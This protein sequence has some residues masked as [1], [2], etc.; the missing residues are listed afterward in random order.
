MGNMDMFTM[1]LAGGERKHVRLAGLKFRQPSGRV[2]LRILDE[3]GVPSPARV[4]VRAADGKA[5]CPSGSPIYY[6]PLGPDA[7]TRDGF[8]LS[9][10]DDTFPAPA[11]KLQLTALKGVE[12]ALSEQSV[13]VPRGDIAEVT[14]TMRRWT[15]WMQRGWYSGENHYHANYNGTYY[16]RP[17]ESMRWLQAEDLNAANM[18][19]ANSEGAFIHDKEFFR[20]APDPLSTGRYILYWGQEYRNSSP[21]GHMAFLNI[22]KQVPPSYTSVIGSDSPYDFPLNTM[23]A[24]EARKQGGLVSYVHPINQGMRDVFDATLGAKE[25]AIGTALGAVDSIDILPFGE[26]AYQLWYRFL[27]CG[28]HI[29]AGAG[30]DAFANWRSINRIPGS[31]RQYVDVGSA[32]TWDRWVSRYREG[33][34]FVTNGPLLTFQINGE[35]PGAVIRVP[36]GS[37]YTARISGE[38]VS[39]FPLRQVD[40]IQ[41]GA[42]L[43]SYQVPADTRTWR[44]DKEVSVARSAWFAF[45]VTG[46]PSRGVPD[47]NGVPRAHS[48]AI[49]IETGSQPVLLKEDVEL[50]VRWVDRFWAL[51]EERHNL[52][53]EA[54]RQKAREMVLRAR[55]H[56]EEKLAQMQ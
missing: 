33:R 19:V 50:M 22:K 29:S 43:E 54:N 31:A 25:M 47:V 3:L 52:G 46:Q 20:G 21:L 26:A 56:Y 32:V 24:L 27:N 1:P 42:I 8:F 51:L 4:Y 28:F 36:A 6:Y 12:Y 5:Y 9:T 39:Q 41:N 16:Q 45:R 34:N 38:V 7:A 11:G 53:S 23:A 44:F 48:G 37:P 2:R 13:D 49:F 55:K 40:L 15:N 30:T 35:P 14:L 18:I 17:I 10:G